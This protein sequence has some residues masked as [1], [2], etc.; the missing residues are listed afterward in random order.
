MQSIKNVA[1]DNIGHSLYFVVVDPIASSKD[2]LPR[3]EIQFVPPNLQ[4]QRNI[5]LNEVQIIG[6]NIPRYQ[7][8]GGATTLSFTLDF[9]ADEQNRVSVINKCRWLETLAHNDGG[10]NP[11][12]R[13]QLFFGSLYG[14]EKWVVG[15]VSYTLSNFSKTHNYLP[16]QAIVDITLCLDSDSNPTWDQT[17]KY[18]EPGQPDGNRPVNLGLGRDTDIALNSYAPSTDNSFEAQ[19]KR[20]LDR[21]RLLGS[22]GS[23]I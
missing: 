2:L 3:L 5:S 17:L 7:Y 11:Q 23:P 20:A 13:V 19:L 15:N 16:Q 12:K 14:V 22:Y 1:V 4:L 9:Y 8:G 6:R 10:K 18:M 21:L